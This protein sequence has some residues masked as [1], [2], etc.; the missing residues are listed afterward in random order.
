MS[1][2]TDLESR[3]KSSS[4]TSTSYSKAGINFRVSSFQPAIFAVGLKTP[5]AAIIKSAEITP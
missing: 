3:S 5:S 2:R 4:D 1:K